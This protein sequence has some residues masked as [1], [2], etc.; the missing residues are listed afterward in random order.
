MTLRVSGR[1]DVIRAAIEKAM[2]AG[3]WEKGLE[4]H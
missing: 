3:G 4:D 2:L 1:D